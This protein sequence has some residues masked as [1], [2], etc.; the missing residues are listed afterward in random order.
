MVQEAVPYLIRPGNFAYKTE[1]QYG[2]GYNWREDNKAQ[3]TS[4]GNCYPHWTDRGG[5]FA[6]T[7][8]IL[9]GHLLSK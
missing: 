2:P 4:K 3:Y 5:A 7:P 9:F 8:L 6:P 1:K